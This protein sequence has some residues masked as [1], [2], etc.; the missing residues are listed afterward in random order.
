MNNIFFAYQKSNL[1]PE[2]QGELERI[3]KLMN[4]YPK[5]KIEVSGHTDNV[6]SREYN[7]KLSQQRA[8]AVANY[9][10]SNGIDKSRIVSVGYGFDKPI[11]DNNSAAG[12]KLNRRSEIKIIGD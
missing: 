4:D 6:G 9:L 2:S 11:S 7:L 8:Q 12:R 10:I 3:L 1:G 5:L